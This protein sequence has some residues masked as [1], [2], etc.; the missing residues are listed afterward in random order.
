M[1]L[2]PLDW[3]VI[4]VYVLFAL[5]VGFV[6]ARRAG[7]GVDEFFLSGRSL[8]WWL[9][10]T[11]L[12]ATTFASDTPLVITGWVR[13]SGIHRNWIWWCMAIGS[14]FTVL[15]FSRY[16]RRGR[17]MTSAEMAELRYGGRSAEVLRLSLGIFQAGFTN[18]ITLCWVIL[19]AAKIQ[20]VIFDIPKAVSIALASMTALIYCS[21]AGLWGVVVTDLVQFLMA[22][23]GSIALAWLA[24]NGVGGIEG[25]RA[26]AA[27]PG[28][29]FTPD[30]LSLFP[31]HGVGALWDASFWT[32][33]VASTAVF[34]GVQWWARES[35]D[36]G[37]LVVQRV[38]AVKSER[39]GVLAVLWY[40]VAH[41]ALRPWP[42]ILVA[43]ASLVVL[44]HLELT[45]PIAGKVTNVD[46]AQSPTWIEVQAEGS[47]PLRLDLASVATEPD[48]KPTLM[49][50]KVGDSVLPGQPLARTDSE[51]AYVVMMGRYLHPGLLGLAVAALLAAFMSTVDTHVN[52][53]ASFFVGDIY[54]RFVHPNATEKHYVLVAR[55]ASAGVLVLAGTF[56][57]LAD[58]IGKLF[59][60]FLTFTAGVGP[61]YLARW[62]WWRVRAETEIVAMFASAIAATWL[63][64]GPAIAGFFEAH[65]GFGGLVPLAQWQWPLGPLAEAN[66]APSGAGRLLLVVGISSLCSIL[67]VL[68]LPKPDPSKLVRFYERVRPMGFWGPVRALRPELTP[69]E[70]PW[71]VLVGSVGGSAAILGLLFTMGGWFL[72]RPELMGYSALVTVLGTAGLVW[73][74]RQMPWQ[75][76]PVE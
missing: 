17:L 50:A 19:A 10:G 42:W 25:V 2:T 21:M 30:T 70:R 33:G 38:S 16:W 9:A 69:L 60:F 75:L 37:P 58:S 23:I 26:A 29:S 68:A 40:N 74:M 67:S 57:Y 31:A 41:F 44:S 64:F 12:V 4:A 7:K 48:W 54:R 45:S 49:V 73:G 36:G 61:V 62:F 56:A 66:G 5:A 34:L 65:L 76:D 32:T 22:M 14:V 71:P 35:A 27:L 51:S 53:A 46:S 39:D 72:D 28:S 3:A 1:Q 15:L 18:A 6:F 63:A 59:E 47:A 52:L 24:W 11:S 8:P 20:G 43:V 55:I 13:E